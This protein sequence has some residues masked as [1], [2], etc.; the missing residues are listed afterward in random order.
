MI[1]STLPAVLPSLSQLPEEA[2]AS[3]GVV[4]QVSDMVISLCQLELY[5]VV[6]VGVVV[7]M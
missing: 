2:R 4:W 1:F 3:V 5:V 7:G 6:A